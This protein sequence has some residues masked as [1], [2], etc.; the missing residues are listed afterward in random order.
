MNY[1]TV[2]GNRRE[3]VYEESNGKFIDVGHIEVECV[4]HRKFK[5]NY[6][7]WLEEATKLFDA[8]VL[9]NKIVKNEYKELK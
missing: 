8:I 4:L 7:K 2:N 6:K 5:K 9:N 1:K 3:F